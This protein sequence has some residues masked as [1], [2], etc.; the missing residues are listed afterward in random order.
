MTKR[1]LGWPSSGLLIVALSLVQ[2]DAGTAQQISVLPALGQIEATTI[3]S[4]DQH[5][6]VLDAK[7]DRIQAIA[8]RHGLTI[9][10]ALN[11]RGNK[12]VYLVRASG[13]TPVDTLVAQVA[14]DDDVAHFELNGIAI[15]PEVPAGIH[16][17]LDQSPVSI[18]DT[19]G[20]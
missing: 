12:N 17:N 9:V 3:D 1:H 15:T 8:T 19:N 18:L 13:I 20:V 10:R 4:V 2:G 14:A 5:E 7:P 16:L 6:F 11:A